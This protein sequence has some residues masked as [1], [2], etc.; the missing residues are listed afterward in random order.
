MTF[1]RVDGVIGSMLAPFFTMQDGYP[2]AGITESQRARTQVWVHMR[3]N[4][5]YLVRW[6]QYSALKHGDLRCFLSCHLDG[7]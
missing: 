3:Y 1:D 7:C 5:T 4:C 2:L 6:A